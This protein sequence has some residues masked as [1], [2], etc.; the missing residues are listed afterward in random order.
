MLTQVENLYNGH[1]ASADAVEHPLELE[2]SKERLK[3]SAPYRAGPKKRDLE[4]Q[5]TESMLAKGAI[6]PVQKDWAS[7]NMFFPKKDGS[8]RFCVN[9]RELNAVL[10]RDWYPM[11]R[12]DDRI[13]SLGDATIFWTLD[14]NKGYWKG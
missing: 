9:Y 1:L 3:H 10:I 8:L 14:E 2:K 7:Q 13:D 11:P 5:E 4:K 6:E 12:M